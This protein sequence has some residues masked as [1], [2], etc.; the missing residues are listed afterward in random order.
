MVLGIAGCNSSSDTANTNA[1][2]D[3]A[4]TSPAAN[5]VKE[6]TGVSFSPLP[7]SANDA[8][9]QQ[10]R[11]SETLTVD[12][13]DGS[14]ASFPLSYKTL[15]KMG[16]TVGTG[17]MGLMVAKNGN[18]LTKS[19]GSQD[20][21]DGPDGNSFFKVGDQ[22][23]LITHLEERPGQL[24]DTKLKIENGNLVPI[25]TK[26]VDLA[27]IG[28]TIINCASSKTAYGS[29][30]GGEE[31]YSLNSIYA[32]SASPFYVDCALDGS[33]NDVNGEFNYF[34][35]YVDQQ[36]KYLVD[37][38]I[39][40]TDGYNGDSFRPYNYGYIVE[41]KPN[42]DGTV[43]SAK[44]YVTG[45]YTP[46]LALMMPDQKTVYMSDDGTAKGL[47]K[48]V[49]DTPINDFQANWSGR[50][51][52]AKVQQTSTE[53]GG[54][55]TVTWVE[56]GQASDQQIKNLI[57]SKMKLTD[58]FSIAEPDANNQCPADFTYVFE[59]GQF[60]CLK[61]VP[62]QETAAAFLESRKYAAYKGATIEFRKEEGLTYD[63]DKN[64]V[65]VAMSAIEKS[66]EDN[67]KDKEPLNH[68][69]LPKESC[70]AV[71]E[72]TL[73]N[74]Y[75][76][77]RMHA[78]VTGKTLDPTDP[79]ASEWYC[80][81]DGIS[82]PD[83]ITYVGHNT[84]LISEDTTKHVNNMSWAYN[85]QNKS[86]TRMASLPIG[87]E[88]TGV[89]T[90]VAADKGL[91]FINIQHPFKDNPKNRA[92]ETPNSSLIANAT[93]EQLKAVI[94]YIDGVPASVFK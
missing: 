39:D 47:W 14:N 73:D 60:E 91:L 68:I 69:R 1:A 9:K 85:T 81:P 15:M 24:M 70:G 51:Y 44:H 43:S 27:A 45:S 4:N 50:L 63:P 78:I 29:H 2:V 71:Y 82:N 74:S 93:D 89:D 67:Y 90:G 5:Q 28:G 57:G 17:T 92:G 31:N 49:S 79:K 86:L 65:Y 26:P 46:E 76:A 42:A 18:P 34:C 59:D 20:I 19:D 55:F 72:L 53:N 77:T 37:T 13:S 8:E 88:V 22:Y 40:K 64:V 62:G 94:G 3:T 56:L 33:S 83:N 25:D 32:D 54:D 23:R 75:S 10:M 41:V 84:L 12:Y 66:M 16:D 38:N 58:I 36:A 30:L 87:G 21:S 7:L 52:A 35:N 61:L 48:F 6:V 80:D 11:V